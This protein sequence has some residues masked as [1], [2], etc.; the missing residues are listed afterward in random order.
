MQLAEPL[1][2]LPVGRLGRYDFAPGFY[3]YVG[4][5]F[6]SGG[7][8]ARIAY[9]RRR[10]KERPHWHVDYLRPYARLREVW[11]VG[12]P[13]HLECVWCRALAA[14]PGLLVP[15]PQ[16]GSRDT[17]CRAHLFYLPRAPHSA[18]LTGVILGAM[19]EAR[20]AELHVEVHSFD[21][22]S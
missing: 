15:V 11:A 16:F 7:L 6:G 17:R 20:L 4:S 13:A 22:E 2:A 10:Q 19:A 5:A 12:G 21:D 3:L 8:D 18:L 1:A 9:H 14:S